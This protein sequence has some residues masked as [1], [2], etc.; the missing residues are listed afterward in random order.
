MLILVWHKSCNPTFCLKTP[1]VS[2]YPGTE[3]TTQAPSEL[4]QYH[5]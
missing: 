4:K 5:Q 2:Y 1:P 3:A